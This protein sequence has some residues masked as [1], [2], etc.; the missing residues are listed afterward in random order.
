VSS[1]AVAQPPAP[2]PPPPSAAAPPLAARSPAAPPA[3]LDAY[4]TRVM[5]AFEVPGVALTVV[6]SGQVLIA[7][8]DLLLKP[9]R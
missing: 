2:P 8:S 1:A 3:D 5:Q 6:T 4:V 7:R 9:V